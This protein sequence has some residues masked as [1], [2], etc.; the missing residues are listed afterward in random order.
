MNDEAIVQLLTEI[1]DT[2]LKDI[3]LREVHLNFSKEMVRK[4]RRMS[5]VFLAI[6]AA[7]MGFI[8]WTLIKSE[9]RAEDWERQQ[10]SEQI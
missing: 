10:N 8:V 9:K 7:F 4:Q 5:R 3:E 1:R 6:F 2:L